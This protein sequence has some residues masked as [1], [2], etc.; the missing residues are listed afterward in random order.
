MNARNLTG[1]R[2]LTGNFNDHYK[3]WLNKTLSS[4][5]PKP[6]CLLTHLRLV[7]RIL[8]IDYNLE[9]LN[10]HNCTNID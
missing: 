4:G 7:L 8:D 10:D 2:A 5:Q 6:K 3:A 1:N 9:N